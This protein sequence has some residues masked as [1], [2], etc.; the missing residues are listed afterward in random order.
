MIHAIF[1]IILMANYFI[2][3]ALAPLMLLST[4]G[5]SYHF[6]CAFALLAGWRLGT[7]FGEIVPFETHTHTHTRGYMRHGNDIVAHISCLIL[8]TSST[9]PQS[10]LIV[11]SVFGSSHFISIRARMRIYYCYDHNLTRKPHT[12]TLLTFVSWQI[13]CAASLKQAEVAW[14]TKK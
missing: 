3:S 5:S 13:V 11:F 10:L 7:N 4:N 2:L 9:L 1:R 12:H 14:H 6:M 8:F